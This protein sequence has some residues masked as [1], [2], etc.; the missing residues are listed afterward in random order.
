MASAS[1]PF[2]ACS[3]PCRVSSAAADDADAPFP[4]ACAA[5]DVIVVAV[6]RS[7]AMRPPILATLRGATASAQNESGML[8]YDNSIAEGAV[9]PVPLCFW[10]LVSQVSLAASAISR[11]L[12]TTRQRA[13]RS[14]A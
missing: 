2:S 11:R 1:S 9:K 14:A 6:R 13:G 7:T 12:S 10:A 8:T 4:S 3:R 5:V